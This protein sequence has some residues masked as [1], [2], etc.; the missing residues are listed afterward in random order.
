MRVG[1]GRIARRRTHKVEHVLPVSL[2]AA[3]DGYAG[4]GDQVPQTNRLVATAAE[5]EVRVARMALEVVD[6][7]PV[8]NQVL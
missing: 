5:H 1:A 7:A 6:R 8:T 4:E 3:E 2:V